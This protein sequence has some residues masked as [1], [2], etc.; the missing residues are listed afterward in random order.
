M[1]GETVKFK[2]ENH[3]L[4]ASPPDG[5]TWPNSLSGRFNPWKIFTV[6]IEQDAGWA[7]N[8]FLDDFFEK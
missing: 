7:P 5:D 8:I 6:Q 3:L 2:K 1:L 4:S